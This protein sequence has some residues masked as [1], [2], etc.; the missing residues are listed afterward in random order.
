MLILI[1]VDVTMTSNNKQCFEKIE[2]P[3]FENEEKNTFRV[4]T[5]VLIAHISVP[6]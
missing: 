3:F 1:D 2:N 5:F 4:L 6:L